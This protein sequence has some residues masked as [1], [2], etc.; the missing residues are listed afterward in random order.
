MSRS[1]IAIC[2]GLTCEL[3]GRALRRG[4]LPHTGRKGIKTGLRKVLKFD[5]ESTAK[6]TQLAAKQQTAVVVR[7]DAG[8]PFNQVAV[9]MDA[10][11]I[12]GVKQVSLATTR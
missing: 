8:A 7:A 12:A 11:E 2:F 10:C 6:I 3:H 9:V 4:K 5:M 1:L